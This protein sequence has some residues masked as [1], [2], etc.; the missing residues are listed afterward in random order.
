MSV[1]ERAKGEGTEYRFYTRQGERASD[2]E[3]E[4]LSAPERVVL[5]LRS[6]RAAAGENASRENASAAVAT[7]PGK[8][9]LV[10]LGG[11]GEQLFAVRRQRRFP[12]PCFQV[13]RAEEKIATV[14]GR[15]LL[16]T[17]YDVSLEGGASWAFY[18]PLYT[19]F[20]HGVSSEAGAVVIRMLR[21]S[22]LWAALFGP[23]QDS[24][25][26]LTCVGLIY[27]ARAKSL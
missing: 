17:S 26:L 21:E 16:R 7:R 8:H 11:S 13:F 24:Q 6:A 23:G 20:F 19:S 25:A 4:I 10:V 2:D 27:Y 15:G 9:D 5:R 3:V 22:F 1:E 18:L 14:Q 12:S